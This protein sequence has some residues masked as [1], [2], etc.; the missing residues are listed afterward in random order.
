MP[1]SEEVSRTQ[2]EDIFDVSKRCKACR[3]KSAE[4]MVPKSRVAIEKDRIVQCNSK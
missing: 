1:L 3:E 2:G 4:V